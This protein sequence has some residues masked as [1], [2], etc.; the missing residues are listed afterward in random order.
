[1]TGVL[2]IPE[3]ADRQPCFFLHGLSEVCVSLENFFPNENSDPT[4]RRSLRMLENKV[5]KTLDLRNETSLEACGLPRIDEEV[6]L[7]GAAG[8]SIGG[9]ERVKEFVTGSGP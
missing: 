5:R 9:L 1:L 6:A 3:E 8:I 4:S 2:L 7:F